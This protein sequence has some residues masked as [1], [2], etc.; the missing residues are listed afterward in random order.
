MTIIA[1]VLYEDQMQSGANGSFPLHDLVMRFV[2]DLI[3]GQTWRL[4]KL[5]FKNPRKGI[6]NVVKDLAFTD[7]I[8]GAGDL[9]LLVDRDRIARHLNLSA[10]ATDAD[11]IRELQNR[12]NAPKKLRVFFLY[13]NLEGLLRDVNTCD[14]ELLPIE[15]ESALAKNL[16]DRDL[17]LLEVKKAA[18]VELRRC[19]GNNQQGLSGLASALANLVTTTIQPW[20]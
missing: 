20:P 6:N 2:E 14:P 11:V 8:A 15:M 1:T 3:N 7:M 4:N 9:F 19:I 13:Q 5:V 17:V 16:N 12:S 10:N 18:N